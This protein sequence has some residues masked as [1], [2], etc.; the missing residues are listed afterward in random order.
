MSGG[1]QVS[2]I[3]FGGR[4]MYIAAMKEPEPLFHIDSCVLQEGNRF[5]S[6]WHSAT[7]QLTCT[8]SKQV[9]CWEQCIVSNSLLYLRC[10][11]KGNIETRTQLHAFSYN[12]LLHFASEWTY[13][14]VCTRSKLHNHVG[15]A[16]SF[17][18]PLWEVFV[19]T[20][21]WYTLIRCCNDFS[22]C[23]LTDTA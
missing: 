6:W 20:H 4:V 18:C 7:A 10:S 14:L 23:L 3:S 19:A 13:S 5:V 12:E 9:L 11:R 17:F 16:W 15:Y 22:L 2:M 8:C 1:W 21:A